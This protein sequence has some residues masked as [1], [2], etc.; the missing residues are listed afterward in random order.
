MPKEREDYR[1]HLLSLHHAFPEK[2]LISKRQ[3]AGYLG[4][5]YHSVLQN[6]EI[7]TVKMGSRDMITI[8]GA[9]RWLSGGAR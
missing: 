1:Y 9:A 6:K 7:P 2:E 4:V 3:F 5:D 8:T